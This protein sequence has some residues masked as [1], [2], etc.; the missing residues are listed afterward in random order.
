MKHFLKIVILFIMGLW[1]NYAEASTR[2]YPWR[3]WQFHV[4]KPDY[5]R[6]V[7]AEA[8]EFDVNTIVLS[9]EII[10]NATDILT[11]DAKNVRGWQANERGLQLQKL[12]RDA[13][14]HNLKTI[15]W[16]HELESVPAP[17]IK[18]GKVN[19]DNDELAEWIKAKYRALYELYPEFDGLML[20]FHETRYK[21]FDNRQVESILT[22]PQRF[23]RLIN[24]LHEVCR[25]Y[26]K[27]LIVRTFLYEPEELAWLREGLAGT[28]EEVIIQ[29]KCVPHDWQ[30]FYPHNPMIGAIPGRKMIIEFDGSSEYTGRNRIAYCN[31]EYFLMRWRYDRQFPEVMGYNARLDHAGFDAFFTPNQINL[32]T[33]S[34][35]LQKPDITAEEIW[36]EWSNKTYGAAAAPEVR[37]ALQPTFDCVNLALFAKGFWYSN[38]SRLSDYDYALKTLNRRSLVKWS[39]EDLSL[40]R[41]EQLLIAP[42]P[43][44]LEE[45]LVEKDQAMALADE[46]LLHL[47]KAKPYLTEEQYDDLHFRLDLLNRVANIWRLHAEAFWGLLLL[48]Q[49]NPP[50]G[51]SHRIERALEALDRQARISEDTPSVGNI[52]PASAQNIRHCTEDLRRRLHAPKHFP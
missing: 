19:F 38:H 1:L 12:A 26:D 16:I 15:I 22:M 17:F 21:I 49:G 47:Q 48:E 4:M 28:S 5:I 6:R 24:L 3:M 32:Y 43:E 36:T 52:E 31:P 41:T 42:T 29:S 14:Q 25:A 40:K 34:R 20:T 46:C 8:H 13:H 37:K 2:I 45:I 11:P 30:P 35:V 50:A 51:L 18:D 10:Y 33:L 7:M 9:H 27:T 39:P 44:F 23:V